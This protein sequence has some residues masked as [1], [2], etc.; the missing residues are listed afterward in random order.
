M[1]MLGRVA[2]ATA[3]MVP[4]V[5]APV[6]AQRWRWD[7]GVNG[8]FSWYS[9]MLGS[10]DTGLPDGSDRDD[11]RFEAGPRVGAQL[12]FWFSPTL[13]LRFNGAYSE[14]DVVDVSWNNEAEHFDNVNLWSGT[15]DLMWRF[16]APNEDW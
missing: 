9:G 16:K 4:V 1:R 2:L 5:V 11:V 10:E 8:G 7:L 14:R 6:E 3:L 12:G 13:G 15:A